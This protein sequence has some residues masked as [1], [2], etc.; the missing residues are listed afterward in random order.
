M[1]KIKS[2]KATPGA[3]RLVESLRDL[4]YDTTT[5]IADLLDNSVS[6]DASEIFVEIRGKSSDS[7]AF[8]M[9][10][11]NGKGMS[12]DELKTA[13]RFGSFQTYTVDHLGKY[14][15][16]LKTA[17]LS[18]CG[19][20]TV[21]SK[22][23]PKSGSRSKISIA[24][25]DISHINKTDDWDLLTP[26]L[27]D[28]ETWQVD[29]IS[30]YLKDSGGTVVIWNELNEALP[31]LEINDSK[32]NENEVARLHMELSDH[33]RM[34]FHR[35]MQGQVRGARRLSINVCGQPLEAW[36]PF[37]LEEKTK[38]L[39]PQGFQIHSTGGATKGQKEK[40]FF[41]PYILPRQDEF[42]SKEAFKE[43]S[44]PKGWNF[45]QGFYFC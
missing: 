2:V 5:A 27:E 31:L 29:L 38:D 20:L 6:A 21:A 22:G 3:K 11:D 4:G 7:P 41:Q 40:V 14:G 33:L 9:I 28:L 8:V 13:M 39:S 1:S 15:L 18:Q 25:W 23:R 16:G 26:D 36:D 30:E 10:S 42:S 12:F 37:C 45:Q 19:V 17:S 35:F 44:G 43:A 24:R 34:V 32:K